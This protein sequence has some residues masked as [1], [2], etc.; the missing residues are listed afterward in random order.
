MD[1]KGKVLGKQS[2]NAPACVCVCVLYEI[3]PA[4]VHW[5]LKSDTL[6]RHGVI[7]AERGFDF[8]TLFLYTTLTNVSSNGH[9]QNYF[10]RYGRL[11]PFV[12]PN[13]KEKKKS[14]TGKKCNR[15][16]LLYFVVRSFFFILAHWGRLFEFF[17]DVGVFCGGGAFF[18]GRVNYCLDGFPK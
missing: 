14:T 5:D 2:S 17:G 16:S 8:P 11:W 15:C 1:K 12:L 9:S 13:A 7:L 10:R 18:V 4:C 6:S 3:L